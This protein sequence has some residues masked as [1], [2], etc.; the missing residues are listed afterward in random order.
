MVHYVECGT[1]FAVHYGDGAAAFFDTFDTMCTQ[2]VKTLQQSEQETIDR[3]LPP[4][5]ALVS[6]HRR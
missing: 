4:L 2:V 6:K 5:E 1:E 3:F